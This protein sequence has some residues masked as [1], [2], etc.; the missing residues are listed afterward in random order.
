ME[1][2]TR[3]LVLCGLR[4]QE[5]EAPLQGEAVRKSSPWERWVAETESFC[6][7]IRLERQ[8]KAAV[9]S[10]ES[11]RGEAEVKVTAS[12]Q[13]FSHESGEVRLGGFRHW[14]NKQGL[15][16]PWLMVGRIPYRE[17]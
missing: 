13:C 2:R 4:R 15:G 6:G 8:D 1:R 14:L 17:V 3:E 7:Q 5:E 10:E 12:K 11:Q 16:T 9:H